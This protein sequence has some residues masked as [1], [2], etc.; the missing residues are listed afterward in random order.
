MLALVYFGGLFPQPSAP[1]VKLG[2]PQWVEL[3]SQTLHARLLKY[4]IWRQR[5]FPPRSRFCEQAIL[6]IMPTI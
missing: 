1:H 3:Q 2:Q 5:S 6:S 4:R